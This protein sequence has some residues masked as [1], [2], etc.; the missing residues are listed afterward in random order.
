MKY[1]ILTGRQVL[2]IV[3]NLILVQ[4]VNAI[5]EYFV[6]ILNVDRYPPNFMTTQTEGGKTNN[7]LENTKFWRPDDQNLATKNILC[8]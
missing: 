8:T 7:K 3:I 2:R 5:F 6:N 4:K 1:L